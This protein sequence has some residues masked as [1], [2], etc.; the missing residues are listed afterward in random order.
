MPAAGRI[1]DV[2]A[3]GIVTG[4]GVPT[5]LIG[6]LP[7]AVAGDIST[8]SSGNVPAPFTVGSMTVMIGGKP[9]IRVGDV[10]GNGSAITV[11]LPTVQIG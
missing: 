1:T 8:P 10:P 9:A 2:T 5:V 3:D 4:A 11:G 6:S 7:A